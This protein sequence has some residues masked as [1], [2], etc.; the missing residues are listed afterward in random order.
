MK[1]PSFWQSKGIIAHLLYPLG[2]IYALATKINLKLHTPQKVTI[3]VICIG[4]LT[5]GGSGK[6]PTAISIASILQDMGYHPFFFFFFYGGKLTNVLVD[7]NRHT[8][9]QVGDEPLLLAHQ[10]PVIVNPDRFQ[11]AQTALSHGAD[12]IIMDDGFQNPKLYKDLSFLVFD[13]SIGYG[14]GYCVPAG[15]LRE[16]VS[17]GIR[18]AQAMIIIGEDKKNLKSQISLPTFMGKITP[19]KPQI[20]TS[21]VIAFAGIGR[22]E[23]FYLTLKELGYNLV[24][25]VDFPDHH[26][27]STKELES[28]ITRAEE[29]NC[30]LI[31]TTKDFVKIPPNLQAKFH[32]LEIEIK[33]QN[34]KEL[35]E[36]IAQKFLTRKDKTIFA[37]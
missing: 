32:A 16:E 2:K 9:E 19:K 23:K 24:E 37:G 36:F 21:D 15:P 20:S 29:Q 6:T 1:T 7:I 4:N 3:P 14:N 12:I 30:E 34:K 10:A 13:G 31:T 17:Q 18:R 33:W 27:Y 26:F 25:T 22:P 8:P 35:Q 11:G 5:A 28:L